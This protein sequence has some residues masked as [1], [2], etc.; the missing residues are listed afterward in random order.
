MKKLYLV[1]IFFICFYTGKSQFVMQNSTHVLQT[2][3][4]HYFNI[5]NT[6]DEGPSGPAQVWDFS[7]LETQSQL[8]SYMY[9]PDETSFS[10]DIDEANAVLEEYDTKFYFRTSPHIIEQYGTVSKSNTIIRYD[11]PFVKMI[12]PFSYGDSYTGD[13]SGTVEGNNN[14]SATFTGSY[15]L[16]ADA[17]GTLVL[18]NKTYH[19]VL[20]IKTNKEQCYNN[21]SCN[22]GT[23]SYKW[24]AK[25]IRYPLLTIIK[26]HSSSGERVIKT[27]YYSK[28][29][30]RKTGENN[31]PLWDEMIQ[32]KIYPNPFDNEF[33]IDYQLAE[34]SD[35]TI[36]IYDNSGRVVHTIHKKSQKAGYY[37]E[38]IKND[39]IGEQLGIYH[40]RIVAG[41]SQISKTIVRG[42]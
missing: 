30:E 35:V 4:E 2:G 40:I 11:K 20:R 33:K 15:T 25:N 37:N 29:K 32:A 17:Y 39:D 27:A 28:T 6:A 21:S 5:C 26:T 8:T 19:N 3:D 36:E 24:Y 10:S 14:Y 1:S 38:I 16:E 22:C 18:P 9:Q 7:K 41:E 42:K 31:D 34:N 12:F 13:F 23:V